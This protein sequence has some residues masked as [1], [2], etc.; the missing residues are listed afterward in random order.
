MR[1]LFTCIPGLGH[2]NP[3]V[4]LARAA[5]AAG[6]EVAFATAPGLAE[7]VASAGFA[8]LPAGLDWDE[9]RLLDTVS[10]LRDVA[11]IYRGEWMMKHLFLDR[12]P[13]AMIP[14]LLQ[15]IESW[16]PDMIVSGTFDYGGPLAAEK[17]G[18]PYASGNYT[19]RWHRWILKFAVGRSIAT[20]RADFGLPPDPELNAFGRYLDFCFAPPS[21]T[22]EGALLRPA[23]TRLVQNRLGSR[24]LPLRQ[25]LWGLKALLLQKVFGRSVRKHPELGAVAPNTYFVADGTRVDGSQ[26][27]AWLQQM[28]AQPTVLVSLGTVLSAEYPEIFD[29]ILAALRDEPVNLVMTMGGRDDPARFG[30]QPANVRIVKF[31]TQ[32]ELAELLPH[33][34]LCVNHAG[35][36]SVMEALLRGVPLVLLPLVSDAP[37]NTQMCLSIGVCAELSPEVWGLSPKGMPVIQADRLTPEILREAILRGL[38]DA[39]I[40]SAAQRVKQELQD[41]LPLAEAV[42][43]LERTAAS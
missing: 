40:R 17:A 26:P 4:P 3:L 15:L 36:S 2:F 27:P 33:M 12:A 13:R 39:S 37:M 32:D 18:L 5:V 14:D 29:K 24:D 6:H 22:F 20:L 31:L 11:P 8:F 7:V 43:L 25:R 38:R 23:L 42:K 9:R 28:P 21:W 19:V 30:P 10:D 1:F 34:D 41:R 35:Y 16:R